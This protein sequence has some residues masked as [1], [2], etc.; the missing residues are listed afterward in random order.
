M[1]DIQNDEFRPNL[2]DVD[3]FSSVEDFEQGSFH[4]QCKIFLLFEIVIL[5]IVL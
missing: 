2:N 3:A 1:L 5:S 4:A